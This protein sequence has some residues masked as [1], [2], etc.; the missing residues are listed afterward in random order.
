[1]TVR[2]V[3]NGRLRNARLRQPSPAGTGLPM[4]R[5]E[6]AD[7]IN[8]HI[9]ARGIGY[10]CI[11]AN[12]IG[13]FERGEHIWP[14]RDYRE[15]LRAI[16]GAASDAELGFHTRRSQPATVAMRKH[17]EQRLQEPI[18]P[19]DVHAA[20]QELGAQLAAFRAE[21]R[22]SQHDLARRV[23]ASRSSIA[24]IETGRQSAPM[25]FWQAADRALNGDGVLVKAA[26][27][28]ADAQR[29]LAVQ[30]A[31]QR[32]AENAALSC[33][34]PDRCACSIVVAR[35]SGRET[36]ALREALRLDV[37][38]FA[39]ALHLATTRVLAWERPAPCPPTLSEHIALDR[40]LA[41]ATPDARARFR[42]LLTGE[43]FCPGGR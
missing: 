10:L 36:R 17:D 14:Q 38:G 28:L 43:G 4:S 15:A 3:P 9:A 35:W 6:L 12:H 13:K 16:L 1:M 42:L 20:Q 37:A 33:A 39:R 29:A 31:A 11:D 21:S 27:H 30:T 19:A 26:L 34:D 23:L 22:W 25:D 8:A 7:L 40:L 32:F 18:S 5:R 24:N 2:R 41:Q